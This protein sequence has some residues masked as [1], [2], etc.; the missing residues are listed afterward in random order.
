MNATERLSDWFTARKRSERI[1][2][3]LTAVSLLCYLVFAKAITPLRGHQMQL[4]T[5]IETHAQQAQTIQAKLSSL[6]PKDIE[7]MRQEKR[8]EVLRAQQELTEAESGLQ[9]LQQQLVPAGQMVNLLRELLRLHKSVQLTSLEKLP[10]VTV[11]K[12]GD[13]GADSA[14][15]TLYKHPLKLILRGKYL[16]LLQYMSAVEHMPWGIFWDDFTLVSTTDSKVE[17]I[18][19]LYTV[20]TERTWFQAG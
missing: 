5:Q 18:V 9:L 17:V 14:A 7:S 19:Q 6:R 2:L 4:L 8:E 1:L 12:E 13:K 3:T 10:V 11:T 15:P 16:D 20:S